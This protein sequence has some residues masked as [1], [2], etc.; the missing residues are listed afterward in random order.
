VVIISTTAIIILLIKLIL[1][2]GLSKEEAVKKVSK[3]TEYKYSEVE[4]LVPKKFL[5]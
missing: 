5:D 4:K 2:Y 3:K 1:M